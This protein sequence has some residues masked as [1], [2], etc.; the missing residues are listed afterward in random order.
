MGKNLISQRRG[1]GTSTYKS[2]G[3]NFVARA[4][5]API[6]REP[7]YGRIMD[8]VHCPGHSAPLALVKY[9]NGESTYLIAGEG[10]RV[11]DIV[12]SGGAETKNGN[13][14]ELKDIPE[15][16]SIYNIELQPG[17]GGK[18]AR[19]T[20]VFAKVT[21]HFPD[22]VSVLLPSKKEKSFDPKCRACIGV[23]AGSGRTEKPFLKAGTMYHKMRARNKLYPHVCGQ[24]M[25]AVDHPHGCSR[26]SKKGR[27]SIARRNAPPG[28]K[29]GL[30][31]PRRTGRRK[32]ATIQFLG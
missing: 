8:I 11:N 5:F 28:A 18:F 19:T 27:P 29:V 22:R 30:I 25:N 7:V 15:G 3:F 24:S 4:C 14:L 23:A 26:S 32:G 31:R 16:T 6:T 2:P 9:D 12:C 21:A 1:R 10:F 20:G 13:T 17:D